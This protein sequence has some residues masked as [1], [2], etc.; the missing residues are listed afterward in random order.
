MG[1]NINLMESVYLNT[2][3][4]QD[5]TNRCLTI[6]SPNQNSA[7]VGQIEEWDEPGA[8]NS[9][10]LLRAKIQ[11]GN[12]ARALIGLCY[13]AELPW[14]AIALTDSNIVQA[15]NSLESYHT[16]L[17]VPRVA[18][19]SALAE[20][21][22][23]DWAER[24]IGRLP[25]ASAFNHVLVHGRRTTNIE[26][27][28]G[29][30]S[31]QNRIG[32]VLVH[33]NHFVSDGTKDHGPAPS[34]ESLSRYNL[35]RQMVRPEMSFQEMASTLSQLSHPDTLA[36]AIVEPEHRRLTIRRNHEGAQFTS[37]TL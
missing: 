6:V 34:V 15:I 37:Y 35:A 32:E 25:R 17:G 10:Y 29:F 30:L 11:E 21:E 23:L 9:L 4:L 2:H 1:A 22:N 13:K 19:A 14:T 7:I 8:E 28:N 26:A 12:Y 3:E 20:A 33:G 5:P 24:T 18:I 36:R 31:V 27:A 16:G